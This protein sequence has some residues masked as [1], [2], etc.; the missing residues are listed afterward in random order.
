MRLIVLDKNFDTIGA[1]PLFRT[2]IW[3]RRYEKLGC[4]EL[5]TAKDYFDLLNQGRY[6]Y[7]NDA[8]ELGVIDEVNYSQDENG[9]RE[10]YAKGNFAEIL[11]ADRVIQPMITLTGSIEDGMRKLVE[12]YAITPID[13]KRKIKHLKLGAKAEIAGTMDI[14]VTGDN[15]SEKLYDI[16]N[17]YGISHRIR[18]D[19]LKNDL[20]FE[21][22]EGKDR[23]DS[24]T[25]NSWAVFSNAFYNIRDV[26]YNRNSASYKN[27]AYVAGAGEGSSRI[28]VEVDIRTDPEEERREIYVDA[29]DL[30]QQDGKG[31]SIP[32]STYKAQLIQRGKEKLSE[33][34]KVETVESGV[35]HLA[36][37]VYKTDFDL[38]DYCTYINTEI[39]IEA[40]KRITEVMEVYEGSA[41]EIKVMFGTDEVTTVHQLIKRE[42]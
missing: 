10:S 14:Q 39:G 33:Y 12:G 6:L 31:N 17:A 3:V 16:G 35:D 23:R 37:L 24:Q 36:N 2:L 25:K 1:I 5:H 29:R 15:L 11:L 21:V 28:V 40:D 30:Q 32:L 18:Y 4:F 13:A 22:W 27:F 34:R 9:N 7:R 38:G 8:D 42:V 20:A 41:T 26:V 19:F